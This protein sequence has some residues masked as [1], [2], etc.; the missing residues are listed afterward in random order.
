MNLNLVLIETSGN[1]NYIFATNKLRENVGASELTY[2]TGTEWAL[3][4]V[5]AISGKRLWTDDPRRLRENLCNPDLNSTI[6]GDGV[7]VEVIVATSGKTLLLVKRR[8]IGQQIVRHVTM[9][10]LECAPGL[11][12]CGVISESFDWKSKSLGDVNEEVHKKFEEVRTSRP[13]PAL[14]FLRLPIVA[15]CQSSGLPASDWDAVVNDEA[16]RSK[17]NIRKRESREDYESRMQR[18]PGLSQMKVSFAKNIGKLETDCDWLAVVHADG[19]GLGEV[20]LKFGKHAKCQPEPPVSDYTKLNEAYVDKFRRFSLALEDCAEKSFLSSLGRVLERDTD[21]WFKLPIL[22]LV[23]GGDDLTIVCDGKVALQF[24][25]NFLTEFE[26]ETEKVGIIREI[27][28]AALGAPRLSACAGVAIIK[29]HFPFSAAYDLAEELIKS[30]KQVK[31]IVIKPKQR[32]DQQDEPWPCSAIDFHALYN[33]ATSELE[34]IRSKLVVDDGCIKLYARPYVVTHSTGLNGADDKGRKWA[35]NHDWEKL[36]SRVEVI[37]K[38]DEGDEERRA[39]PNSQLHDLRAGLFLGKGAANDRFRLINHR[40][41]KAGL[42]VF[43]ESADQL[44]FN[45]QDN[46]SATKLLDAMDAANFWIRE[47]RKND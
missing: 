42:K 9:K 15:E 17:V 18:L 35:E 29:P 46:K 22:P 38:P 31:Q 6:G 21:V 23:L 47:E 44:F 40:Y 3:E 37:L 7:E 1:Q 19:N 24:T 12:V 33:S 2:R 11:D 45:D 43:E 5:E 13:G 27:A 26:K 30:A 25:R 14:R 34:D 4:A 16:A 41:E 28:E 36:K 32:E 10:A 8:E 39:L 20:F